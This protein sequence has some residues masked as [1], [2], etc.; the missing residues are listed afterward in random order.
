MRLILFFT[1][2]F[3]SGALLGQSLRISNPVCEY[4]NNPVGVDVPSPRFSWQLVS[5]KNDVLQ[6]A[7]EIRVATDEALLGKDQ[8]LFWQSGKVQSDQSIHVPYSGPSLKS[9]QRYY[10]QVRV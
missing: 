9:R 7:Y 2:T 8:S 5:T 1:L 10:W 3:L 4:Q 6:T